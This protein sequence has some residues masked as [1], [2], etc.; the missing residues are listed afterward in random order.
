[1]N[2]IPRRAR[3]EPGLAVPAAFDFL[4]RIEEPG[5]LYTA[6]RYR[7][8]AGDILP[9]FTQGA[10][11]WLRGLPLA[12]MAVLETGGGASTLWLRKRCRLVTTIEHMPELCQEL[13]IPCHPTREEYVAAIAAEPATYELVILDGHWRAETAVLAARRVRVGGHLL[14]DNWQQASAHLVF[15]DDLV[16]ELRGLFDSLVVYPQPPHPD[17]QTAVFSARNRV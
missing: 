7:D 3:E 13:G 8:E 6:P 11:A 5:G 17:W 15:P 2:P 12:G 10:L 16:A 1:M 9:W 4:H 14:V